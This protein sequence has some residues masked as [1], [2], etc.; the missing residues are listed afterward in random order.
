MGAE[1]MKC[2]CPETGR[3]RYR[4]TVRI[5]SP[6]G[7]ADESGH[8]DLTDDANWTSIGNVK[9]N[10]I[11]KGSREGRIFDQ[12]QAEVTHIIETPSTVL[13][14]S[15]HP[16][17]RVVF[18]GRKFNVTAAYDVNEERH[19]VQVHLTEVV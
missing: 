8:V 15:I 9:A 10:F 16:E 19:E 17:D 5:E 13:S 12:V 4:H 7:T 3:K 1:L 14:R 18:D 11:T 2:A 6:G